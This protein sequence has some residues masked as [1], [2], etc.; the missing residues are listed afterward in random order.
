MHPESS[1]LPLS[2]L[3]HLIFCERQCALIHI[4][5]E[6]EENS[7]TLEGRDLH[8]KVDS[9][10]LESRGDLRIARGLHLRSFRL[11]LSGIADVVEFHRLKNSEEGG[12]SL[13]GA[14]GRW[15]PFPVEYK[16]G[17]RKY[18]LANE[19]QLCAQ[20]MCLEEM[21]G[22]TVSDGALFYGKSQ[23]RLE[24]AF[25]PG[26]RFRTEAAAMRLHELIDSGRTPIARREP[27]CDDCSLLE[28]CRPEAPERSAIRYLR[29]AMAS[30]ARGDPA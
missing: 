20:A 21:L 12:A 28:I 18:R 26:L 8:E 25:T 3:Q 17:K 9:G 16:R 29:L 19:V 2:A 22:C 6:W 4:E 5:R 7:A 27:K 24:V 10:Q 11:G 23:R 15:S 13:P 1:L 14:A 30:A